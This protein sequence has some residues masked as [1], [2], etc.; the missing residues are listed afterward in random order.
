MQIVMKYNYITHFTYTDFY[1]FLVCLGSMVSIFY[2]YCVITAAVEL[3][4]YFYASVTKDYFA[5]SADTFCTV[6]GHQ[7]VL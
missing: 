7:Y 1:P 2:V 6:L 4:N 3:C 5:V